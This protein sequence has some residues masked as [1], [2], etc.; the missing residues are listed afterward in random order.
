MGNPLGIG[1]LPID[2]NSKKYS[3][4]ESLNHLPHPI[5]G[6]RRRKLQNSEGNFKTREEI[7][8]EFDILNGMFTLMDNC[9]NGQE[10]EVPYKEIVDLVSL[11]EDSDYHELWS[12]I[13]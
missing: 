6:Q 11:K 3:E 4:E 2:P 8:K 1:T 10:Q 12:D 7:M 13:M 9:Q 5:R